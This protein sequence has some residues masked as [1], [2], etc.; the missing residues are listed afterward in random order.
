MSST[1]GD[2][3]PVPLRLRDGRR[4]TVRP[5]RPEDREEMK[6]VMQ[7]LSAE[8]RYSRFMSP[9]RELPPRMLERAVHPAPDRELQLVA[10]VREETRE[11]IVAGA[12]YSAAPGNRECEFAITVDDDWQGAG[13]ARRLLEA[14]MASARARGYERM[15]GYILASNSRMLGLAQRLGFERVASPEDPTVRLVRRGLACAR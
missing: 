1:P 10:V 7:R 2:F 5:V 4:V 6:A 13:L 3:V 12:R 9:L 11:R 8:S 15:E 14:L